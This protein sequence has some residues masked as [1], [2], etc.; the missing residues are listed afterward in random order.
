MQFNQYLANS[1]LRT[2]AI[3]SVS[4]IILLVLGT[5]TLISVRD[6]TRNYLEAVQWRSEALAQGILNQV[7]NNQEYDPNYYVNNPALLSVFSLQCQ[8]LYELNRE[9]YVAHIAILAAD[10]SIAAHNDESLWQQPISAAGL[11]EALDRQTGSMFFDGEIYH[12]L[13]PFFSPQQTHLGSIDIGFPHRVVAEK[14]QETLAKTLVV[15]GVFVVIAIGATSLLMHIM[16]IHPINA[17]VDLG[18]HLAEGNLVDV[19]LSRFRGREIRNL[20]GVFR[21]IALY[22]QHITGIAGSITAGELDCDVKVRSNHDALGGAIQ[23]MVTYLALVAG[24]AVNIARGDLTETLQARSPS[25]RFGWAIQT[26]VD[27]LRSLIVRIRESSEEIVATGQ[28]IAAL[29]A[30]NID[31]VKNVNASAESMMGTMNILGASVQHVTG[32]MEELST[33]SEQ[34]SQS[35]TQMTAS[36]GRIAANATEL[37]EHTRQTIVSLHDTVQSLDSVVENTDASQQLSQATTADALAGQQSV[38]HVMKSMEA[39]QA[40]ITEATDEIGGFAERSQAIDQVLDVIRNVADQTTLLALNAS[41]IAAQAGTHGRGFAVVADEI[42]NLADEVTHST[43]DIAKI[44]HALQQD[45]QRVVHTIHA[46]AANMEQS[47]QRTQDARQTLEKITQ[48]VRR[49]S[50]V[51]SDIAAALHVLKDTSYTVVSAMQRVDTMADDI[52]RA[53]TS[54]HTATAQ[55]QTSVTSMNGMASSIK[56]A[57]VEQTEGIEGILATTRDVTVLMEQNLESSQRVTDNTQQLVKQADLLLHSI[58]RFTLA[59]GEAS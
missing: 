48:S 23:K 6:F 53:T 25:D 22:F 47:L 44:V 40:A 19:E 52:T 39:L 43:A 8:Q 56:Q 15:F 27:G 35:V 12:I 11:R 24:R 20:V 51:V 54:Q 18:G 21:E 57:T 3:V 30:Q 59:K 34:T 46:G 36:I 37:Q 16:I 5:N 49:S 33:I 31:I 2:Q 9:N 41:I 4:V 7:A 50:D 13:I 17:I 28:H 29:S 58:D 10:G 55:I 45:T 32:N 42:K 26:M 38:E 14:V 1:S